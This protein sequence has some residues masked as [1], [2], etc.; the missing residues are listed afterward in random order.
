MY[1]TEY[2]LNH[3]EIP[4]KIN[5]RTGETTQLKSR[6]NNIPEGKEVFKSEAIFRKDYTNTWNF[7]KRVLTPIEFKA[8]HTLVLMAK[9]KTNSLEPL[10]DDTTLKELME[11]LDVSI[12]KVKPIINKLWELGVYGKFNIKE[13]DKPYT[14]YWV[15]NPYLSFS[16]QIIA[17]DIARLFSNTHCAK[18]FKD[19]EYKYI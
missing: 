1:R 15:L 11:I 9:S 10:N 8:A 13:V 6:K 18:A 14:K 5:T 2:N 3:D 16:G 4:A 12:N 17:S 19:P 7:L